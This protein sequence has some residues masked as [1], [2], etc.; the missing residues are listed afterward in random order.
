MYE[1]YDSLCEEHRGIKTTFKDMTKSYYYPSIRKD[2]DKYVKK[3]GIS[4]E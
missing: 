2:V 3:I 4:K 1:V